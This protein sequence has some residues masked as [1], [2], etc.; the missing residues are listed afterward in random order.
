MELRQ[1]LQAPD[2]IIKV[3]KGRTIKIRPLTIAKQLAGS[4]NVVGLSGGYG[5]RVTVPDIDHAIA[6]A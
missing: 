5:V 2:Y 3:A 1:Q 6:L 4:K